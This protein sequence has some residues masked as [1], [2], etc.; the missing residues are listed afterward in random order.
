MHWWNLNIYFVNDADIKI[1]SFREPEVVILDN[2]PYSRVYNDLPAGHLV[3][4]KI[5]ICE[6][7]G[8]IRLPNEGLNFC[9]RQGKV[10]IVSTP[11]L[12][13]LWRLFTS[14][15]IEMPCISEKIY[16]TS[17]LIFHSQALELMWT[18]KS[19]LQRVSISR[20]FPISFIVYII[21][22]RPC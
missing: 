19:L 3:L 11:I 21:N 1:V 10:N 12:P 9:C 4:R 5:P 17:I 2:D 14:R 18:I 7:C 16:G 6:Y 22:N 20:R 8:A 13:D 15:Q